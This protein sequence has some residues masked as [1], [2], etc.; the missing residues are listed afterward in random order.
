MY[1][2]SSAADKT[3]YFYNGTDWIPMDGSAAGTMS[4]FYIRDSVGT[5]DETITNDTY[6]QFTASTGTAGVALSGSGTTGAPYVVGISL[7][8]TNTEYTAGDGLTLNTLEFDVNVD[9]TSQVVV[10]NS[11]TSTLLRTYAVQ[12]DDQA[13][14]LVVNVPW[15]DNNSQNT[16]VLQKP[17]ASNELGLFLNGSASAQ[18]N[19]KFANNDGNIDID[20][21]V[22]DTFGIELADD[23][24][25]AASLTVGTTATVTGELIVS[26]T[27]QSSFAGQVTVQATPSA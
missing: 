11:L 8:D 27:G 5:Q 10:A 25:I 3:M 20:S 17:A 16:Y 15:T 4:Q 2:D 1:F 19:V 22:I 18:N 6:V 9:T 14:N 21:S 7:P 26:G 12:L 13:E 23:V 24:D